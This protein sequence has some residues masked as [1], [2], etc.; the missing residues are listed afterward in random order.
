MVKCSKTQT[1]DYD[2]AV[3]APADPSRE[4]YTF[5]GWD[6][7]FSN[8]TEDLTVTEQY[9]I[10]HV[11]SAEVTWFNSNLQ[12]KNNKN[13]FFTVTVTMSDGTVYTAMS[14]G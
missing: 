8:V 9:E 6:K 13:L 12:D 3:T 1:V 11:V 4:G 14:S 2:T 10:I 7:E 5:S